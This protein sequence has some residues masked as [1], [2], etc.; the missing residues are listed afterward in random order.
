MNEIARLGGR[1]ITVLPANRK[2]NTTFRQRLA[3]PNNASNDE[4][5]EWQEVLRLIDE[6]TN[7]NSEIVEQVRDIFRVSVPEQTSKEGYRLLWFHS[8][9]KEA[10][11]AETRARQIERA[12]RELEESAKTG[13]RTADSLSI[14]RQNRI[15][16]QGDS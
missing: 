16:R 12:E 13:R 1:F 9:K 15:G 8:A 6:F 10:N 4:P 5:I 3:R 14:Q 11:D 7:E 2:E